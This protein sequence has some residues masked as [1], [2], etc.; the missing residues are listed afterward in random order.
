MSLGE[1]LGLEGKAQQPGDA[2]ACRT[3]AG[4]HEA[5]FADVAPSSGPAA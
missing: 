1:A 2:D 3:R 5:Q 4:E